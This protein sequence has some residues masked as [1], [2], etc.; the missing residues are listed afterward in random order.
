MVKTV[1]G[2]IVASLF[3][4]AVYGAGVSASS[5]QSV[6]FKRDI[7]PIFASH[8][9]QCHGQKLALGQ[10]RLDSKKLALQGGISGA[11]IKPGNSG[12]SLLV[13]RILGLDGQ[14]RMPMGGKP[15]SDA[16][17]TLIR[18]WIDQGANWPDDATSEEPAIRKHWA[19]VKPVR[20]AAPSVS[21]PEWVKNPIDAFVLSRLEK[22]SLAPSPEASREKLLRRVYLDLIGLPP[23]PADVDQFVADKSPMAYERVV[24]RLLASKHYGER[25]TRHWLDLARYADS[26]GYEKDNLREMWKY[27]DW[28]IDAFNADM[29][30][31]RFTIEQIAGDM[32]PNATVNQRIATGFHRNTMLNQEGGID[33][34]EAR[35]ETIVDRVNTT[36][37]VW[38]GS[39][40]A[41]AQCHNHKYDPFSQKD[42][43][44]FYAFFETSDYRIGYQGTEMDEN[45]RFVKEPEVLLASP[46]QEARKAEIER[47][48]S[49]LTDALKQKNARLDAAQGLWEARLRTA[50][51]SWIT[52][53]PA[54]LKSEGGTVLTRESD[55]S[56][57][58][59]GANP[60]I[61]T[62]AI[63]S[64]TDATRL[65]ALRV[66]ALADP[67]LPQGG[68]GR[69]PYGN[70]LL[71]GVDVEIEPAIA[72]PTRKRANGATRQSRVIIKDARVDDS[73]YTFEAKRFLE[74]KPTNAAVDNPK[75]WYINATRD[76]G[77]RLDR[78]AVFV[79]DKPIGY[80]GGSVIT[81]K[82][83][84]AG[85]ALGQGIGRFRI[86]V[87]TEP[88][89]LFV[90]SV[91]ARLRRVLN[92]LPEG[93]TSKE[94]SDLTT[95][96]RNTTPLLKTERDRIAELRRQLTVLGI[97]SAQVMGEKESS[98]RPST[99]LRERG[100]FLNKGEKVFAGV[101]AALHPLKNNL[102]Q[103]R[104]GL[105]YWLVDENN[106]LTA[107]VAVNRIWEQ[108]FG[109]GLVETSEDF[110]SQS[111][112]PSHSD[113]LDWLASEFVAQKWSIKSLARVIVT[114]ATY[115]QSSSV[116][117]AAYERDQYNRLLARGPRFRME[118]EMIRDV[119]LAAAGTL[120]PRIGGKS[121]FPIQPEGI[122]R[123]P[124]SRVKW[125]TSP[126]DDR[127]RR[128]IY[129]FIRRTSPYPS[130]MAFDGTSREVCTVR[131]VRTNTPL[132]ALAGLNDE[133]AF[134]AA[135]ELA[136][137]IER[138][139]GADADSRI[140]Y[141]MLLCVARRPNSEELSRLK[142]FF[143]LE[144]SRFARDPESAR[145]TVG[146]GK[147]TTK[148]DSERAAWIMIANVL[149]NL[150]ETLTKE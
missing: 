47:E 23:G 101:P 99:F 43:Y 96:F 146:S 114:S 88:N 72:R 116:T 13:Q 49:N 1:K 121:V 68:P 18:T 61:E 10:L 91:P 51:K 75:G 44:R 35:F 117:P 126:G 95:Q 130:Y 67:S 145:K 93:R 92:V 63:T 86:S 144:R 84:F 7:E 36:A 110:G 108:F 12:A 139:G 53:D 32:L 97:V 70:F 104:L 109:R 6:D 123:N 3:I 56:V 45:S 25:M 128:S 148:T 29:P 77:A 87:T 16:Q 52:L 118:A 147:P 125:E 34:E 150:D 124:Y 107:R 78:Q 112:P 58:A 89:P 14:P 132:Q 83:K 26:N 122:W 60:E 133:A 100:G 127:H 94:A 59:S 119:A 39:T 138:E 129:T 17:I 41:C 31:D 143:E 135:R 19:Y 11:P 4:L 20:P 73:A 79:F 40:L 57:L 80:P 90:V 113:L 22:E 5:G 9:Y 74:Q 142:S 48:I 37:T 30:F 115:R 66:E 38:L 28:L 42:Y 71:T 103:N 46:E 106:P 50:P 24:D 69:D 111:S 33:P 105:A 102:P 21:R 64:R 137:R 82:L 120:S 85:G 2:I 15:L 62:Y 65:T 98:E 54:A 131:R 149:L 81:V 140:S 136:A 134:E 8:C 27:R 55:Q 76:V 141:G